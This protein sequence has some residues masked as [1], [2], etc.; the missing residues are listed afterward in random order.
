MNTP[1]TDSGRCSVLL[2]AASWNVLRFA[3]ANG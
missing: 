2:P 3:P 1:T